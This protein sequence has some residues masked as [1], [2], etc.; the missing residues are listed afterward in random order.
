MV[1]VTLKTSATTKKIEIT[2]GMIRTTGMTGRI[3][4][5]GTGITIMISPVPEV[6]STTIVVVVVNR[7]RDN[8]KSVLS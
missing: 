3:M 5:A 8:S 4:P 2:T 1:A 6:T 7:V